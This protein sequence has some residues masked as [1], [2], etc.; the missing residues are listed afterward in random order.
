LIPEFGKDQISRYGDKLIDP[1]SIKDSL[2][3]P[4][5]VDYLNG[6]YAIADF[7]N[8]RILIGSQDNWIS[9]GKEGKAEGE[10]Y[11][12]T[13]VHLT[14]DKIYVADAYNNRVQV[15]DHKGQFLQTFGKEEKMNAATGITVSDTEVFVTDFENDRI[16]IYTLDGNLSQIIDANVSKPTDLILNKGLLYVTNYKGKSLSVFKK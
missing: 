10:F 2:D 16:L 13:D 7:Y 4:A 3:A 8:H 15:F 9:F 6:T 12:P 11:Y 5:G 14:S 1:L